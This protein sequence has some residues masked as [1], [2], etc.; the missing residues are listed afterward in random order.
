[1]ELRADAARNRSNILEAA[2]EVF[3]EQGLDA[4]LDEIAKKAGAGNAT[5]Y[6]RFPTRA[7]LIAEV[8]AEQMAEHL[9]AVEVG[10]GDPDPWRGFVSYVRT[11]CA[12]QTRDRGIADLVTMDVSSAPEIERLRSRAF[13]GLVRLVERAR[14]AAVLRAD[15]STEDVVVILMANAGLVERASSV[16]AD[17]S[18]RL[19]HVL[20]DGLRSAAATEGPPAPSPRRMRLAMR[21]NG[22]RRLGSTGRTPSSLRSDRTF[23]GRRRSHRSA[24]KS[25]GE[26]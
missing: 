18:G 5:L 6:R 19:V 13:E 20:L 15:F 2:R 1:V 23:K 7:D 11:A 17:A 26:A 8:F 16:A 21:R 3:A 12:M 10:L 9:D 22:E 25:K 24:S 4:P 14:S